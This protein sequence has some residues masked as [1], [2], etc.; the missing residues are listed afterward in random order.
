MQQLR[1]PAQN[2]DIKKRIEALIEREFLERDPEDVT[3]YKY[4]A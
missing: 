4:L 1:F 3:F 2:S